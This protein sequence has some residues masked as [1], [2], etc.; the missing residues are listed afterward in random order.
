MLEPERNLITHTEAFRDHTRPQTAAAEEVDPMFVGAQLYTVRE[1][2]KTLEGLSL[3]LRK[4][5]DMG[6]EY[7][8]LSGTC[9]YDAAWLRDELKKNGL[10]CVITHTPAARLTGETENVIRDH[11]IFGCEHVGLGMWKL[12]M[13]NLKE[14]YEAFLTAYRPVMRAVRDAGLTFMYHNHDQEF[15][16]L[17]Q[18][19]VLYRMARDTLSERM[20]FTLDTYWVQ[21][22]GEDPARCLENL[23]GRVPCIHLKDYG[24]GAKMLPVG[25]GNLNFDR[26]F[27]KAA[28]CGTRYMLVEQ[29]DCNGEDPFDCLSRSLSFLR[30]RGF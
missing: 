30:S 26:V 1:H 21:R 29:D 13:E 3:S 28:K 19:P 15:A 2:C 17:G 27:D 4:I 16:H 25:E 24:Y 11:R 10:S 22:G 20:G 6:Y 8:Q 7:V 9:A 12:E 5:A 14:S 23:S 18:E